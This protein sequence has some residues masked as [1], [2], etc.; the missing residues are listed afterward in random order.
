MLGS[1]AAILQFRKSIIIIVIANARTRKDGSMKTLKWFVLIAL[2]CG[3]FGPA[4]KG[5]TIDGT[6]ESAYGPPLAVQTLGSN[7]SATDPTNG[8]LTISSGSQ[9]DA[10]YGVIS[11]STLYLV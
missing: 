5:I 1:G 2:M 11:N 7:A 8:N 6:A 10:A 9:L 4:V 3:L